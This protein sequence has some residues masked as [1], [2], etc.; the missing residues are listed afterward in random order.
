[1]KHIQI[2]FILLFSISCDHQK[3]TG[4]KEVVENST[5]SDELSFQE[6]DLN[7]L[8]LESTETFKTREKE[9]VISSPPV[10]LDTTT[11]N[12]RIQTLLKNTDQT[13]IRG[14]TT[15]SNFT[16]YFVDELILNLAV[17]DKI[18]HARKL[19]QRSDLYE[20]IP[21]TDLPKYSI[22]RYRL[23]ESNSNETVFALMLCQPDT[24]ICY[25]FR[26]ILGHDG[27]IGFVDLDE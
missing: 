12:I 3:K 21:D 17:K 26:H 27:T 6:I 23:I 24:D 7:D 15:N 5:K 11:N 20:Y 1:M 2:L 9:N 18:I 19:I 10:F 16:K 22:T 4:N 13:I 8:Y 14:N 25:R